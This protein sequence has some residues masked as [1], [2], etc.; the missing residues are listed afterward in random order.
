MDNGEPY[1]ND[2]RVN[3]YFQ[4]LAA[5]IRKGHGC[6]STHSGTSRVIEQYE[7]RTVFDG[8]V[9]TFTLSGHA[10]ASEA[11]AWG[12]DNGS[13]PQYVA[14]LRVPPVNDPSDAVRAAIASG[15]FR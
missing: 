4:C 6:D 13:E 12:W 8:E 5:T 15:A 1:G 14:V 10:T 9:E 11:F 3:A 7:G 2:R